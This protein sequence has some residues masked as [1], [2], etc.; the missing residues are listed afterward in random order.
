MLVTGGATSIEG[1]D[2]PAAKF[3]QGI[4]AVLPL[5]VAPK[6]EAVHG[7]W[8]ILCYILEMLVL[9][10]YCLKLY[11]PNRAW[12]IQPSK[13]PEFILPKPF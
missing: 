11:H 2:V 10:R 8:S 5:N 12:L 9:V 4:P 1:E 7:M 13:T 6:S 3:I